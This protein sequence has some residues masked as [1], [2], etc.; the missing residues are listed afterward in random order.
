M[1][2]LLNINKMASFY[3]RVQCMLLFLV[4]EVNSAQFR[5]YVV[6]CSYSSHPF[7]CTL[8][9]SKEF[10]LEIIAYFPIQETV[11]KIIKYD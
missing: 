1:C 9:A 3:A 5:I 6:T 8:A 11:Y 2:T 4:L 10:N 7:L